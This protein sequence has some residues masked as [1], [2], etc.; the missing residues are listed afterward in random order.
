[1]RY[2]HALVIGGSSGIGRELA[3]QLTRAGAKVVVVARRPL[4]E[5]GVLSFQ[6][7]VRKWEDVPE[8]FA[9]VAQELGGLDLVIYAAGVMPAVGPEEF[10]FEKDRQMIEV[11]VLGAIAWINQAALRF[12]A[13][14]A[15]T[16]VGIGS[17]A[18]DRGRA[19]QPVY[20]ASKA[21][22]A[23]YLEAVRNRLW[24]KGVTVVTIKPGPV[25]T[26]MTAHLDLKGALEAEEAARR[27]LARIGR[28]G[29]HYLKPAHRV[30]FGMIR[31]IP[32]WLFR[33]LPL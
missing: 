3:L 12:Q 16:I 32:G 8:L 21:A 23:T 7:D 27:I 29:E 17:V 5:P 2:H 26:P 22:L 33:R 14:G 10:E 4:E 9:R 30:A 19:G 25:R 11:N 28:S 13:V 15:G 24:R 18:G 20:N 6:H 31:L 1:M